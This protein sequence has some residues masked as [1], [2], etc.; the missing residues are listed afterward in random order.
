MK[1]GR[2]K[3]QNESTCHALTVQNSACVLT[4]ISYSYLGNPNWESWGKKAKWF[5]QDHTV[6]QNISIQIKQSVSRVTV[7]YTY[8]T[9]WDYK[10]KKYIKKNKAKW[11]ILGRTSKGAKKVTKGILSAL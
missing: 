2:E 6:K 5:L 4:H 7:V 8:T 11:W 1:L 3:I 10:V 9:S